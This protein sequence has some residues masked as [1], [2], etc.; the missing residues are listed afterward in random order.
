M[1]VGLYVTSILTNIAATN[2]L[3]TLRTLNSNMERTQQQ[4][5]SGL[6]VQTA[7]D[8]VAYWSIS[9]TM[10]SDTD[11]IAAASDAL[12]LGTA[13]VDT[14]YQGMEAVIDVLDEFKAK[15]VTAKE[16]SVDRGQIQLELD[17]LKEQVVSI[18]NGA[19]FS[20]ENWL[21]T[22][23]ADIYDNTINKSSVV[24]GFT[25]T[26]S[27][28]SVQKMESDLS[29]ISLFNTTGGGLLQ[30]DARDAYT[31]GGIRYPTSYFSYSDATVYYTDDGSMDWM[32]PERSTG[33]A[34]LFALNNFPDEAPLDFNAAG[35]NISFTLL[36]DK[37]VED[38]SQLPGPYF[39]GVSTT[40]TIT[41]ADVD[42][43]DASL[44]GVIS[45][46]TQ[47]AGVLNR[48]LNPLGA[49]VSA[50]SF[51]YDPP[52][53]K[54][55][56]HDPK[57][58]SIM[59]LQ[60]NGDGSYVGISNL[61][62]TGVS[63][64]GLK[65]NS[66]YGLRGSS[67][68]LEFRDFTLYNDGENE[69]GIEINFNFAVNGA[70]QKSYSFDR[71]YVNTLLNKTDGT[72]A[73]AEEMETL[74]HSLLD[75]DWPNLVIEATDATH[76]TIKSDPA[77]D[78]KWGSGTSIT[79]SQIRVSN[80]PRPALDFIDIDI[81]ENP[82]NIDNY[83]SYIETAKS[84]VVDGA[85]FLGSLQQ[86]LDM[87]TSFNST[88]MDNIE[89]GVSRLVDTDMEEASARLSAIQTQ[90]QLAVQTLQIANSS[91]ETIMQLFNS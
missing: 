65:E 70:S 63:N 7:A 20:G 85:A 29:S 86:R 59:T 88:L 64:G 51:M 62:S 24:S 11:A 37:E 52:D 40:I 17:K 53:S 22:D 25:R 72:V 49:L 18:A 9:T 28:V 89:S 73:T 19:S 26:A 35:S 4:V 82:D 83:L 80:E 57:K 44:G 31:V 56:V 34:G 1:L 58:M 12:G 43:Y 90:Q 14:A 23:I 32:T 47:F 13:K 27:G 91:S 69:D 21:N 16:T 81:E 2:A 15:L 78:R 48:Q 84:R 38:P 76:V 5:S 77:V 74:L 8:N 10:R 67:L 61:S 30:A 55:R 3:Q 42:A 71:T 36:L 66:A 50:D 79:F 87:Q 46:N 60:K 39:G 41:K 45:T 6:R 68:S 33:S 54:N 75:A